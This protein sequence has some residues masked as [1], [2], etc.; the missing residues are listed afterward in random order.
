[1]PKEI[2]RGEHTIEDT[3]LPTPEVEIPFVHVGWDRKGFVQV[4]TVAPA[5][6]VAPYDPVQKK[7]VI[8]QDAHDPGWF[9]GLDRDGINQLIRN[10]RKA[11]DA[12]FGKDE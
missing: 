2:V 9:V 6:R 3:G 10:L 11:R 8:A 12:A 1:M 5:G 4:A 7:H